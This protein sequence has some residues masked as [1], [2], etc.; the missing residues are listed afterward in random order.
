MQVE[1]AHRS[2]VTFHRFAAVGWFRPNR[3]WGSVRRRQHGARVQRGKP[4]TGRVFVLRY[5]FANLNIEST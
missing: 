1:S 4:P 2:L 5:D 3:V